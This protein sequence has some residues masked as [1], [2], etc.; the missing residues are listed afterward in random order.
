MVH[1]PG[2]GQVWLGRDLQGA[3]GSHRRGLQCGG[4]GGRAT[5][6]HSPAGHWLEAHLH[7]LQ[8]LRSPEGSQPHTGNPPD[9]GCSMHA[10]QDTESDDWFQMR[11][12]K[13]MSGASKTQRRIMS[14]HGTFTAAVCPDVVMYLPTWT[15]TEC[16]MQLRTAHIKPA[17]GGWQRSTNFISVGRLGRRP[18]HP[19]LRQALRGL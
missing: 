1:A 19:P 7:R 4:G 18:G 12:Y 15:H 9:L 13:S 17:H 2:A 8:G 3:G 6:I 16:S 11:L 5:P 14:K 10:L